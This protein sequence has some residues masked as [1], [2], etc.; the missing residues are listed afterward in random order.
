MEHPHWRGMGLFAAALCGLSAVGPVPRAAAAEPPRLELEMPPGGPFTRGDQVLVPVFL[1]MEPGRFKYVSFGLETE[2]QASLFFAL[3][4]ALIAMPGVDYF[5]DRIVDSRHVAAGVGD[6]DF[7]RSVGVVPV[8]EGRVGLGTLIVEIGAAAPER[9]VLTVAAGTRSVTGPPE[10]ALE[11]KV[12][13]SLDRVEVRLP[14]MDHAFVRGDSN[15]DGVI[16]V[17]DAVQAIQAIFLDAGS[18]PCGDA[19]DA[20]DDGRL[21]IADPFF[22]LN[23]VFQA[24]P[25]PPAPFPNAGSDPTADGLTCG[26][27]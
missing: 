2:G 7:E 21:D 17:S 1:R 16:D 26:G 5:H 18:E 13:V 3:S 27:G 10:L 19:V 15:R 4:A 23:F 25:R 12:I 14:L 9:G 8:P 11:G 24:G 20:N 22:L 6:F